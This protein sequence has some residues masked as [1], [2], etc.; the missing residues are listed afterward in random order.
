MKVQKTY[1]LKGIKR[2]VKEDEINEMNGIKNGTKRKQA[3]NQY[4]KIYQIIYFI[5]LII[6]H[7]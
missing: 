2:S 3:M 6:M 5:K 7:Y 1:E 4:L